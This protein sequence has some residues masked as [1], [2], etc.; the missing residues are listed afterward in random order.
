MEGGLPISTEASPRLEPALKWMGH[1][2]VPDDSCEE[3][4]VE[5]DVRG[6]V[7]KHYR[8]LAIN[9]MLLRWFS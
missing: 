1:R 8:R 6:W 4:A 7:L 3:F 5:V 2:E 9:T